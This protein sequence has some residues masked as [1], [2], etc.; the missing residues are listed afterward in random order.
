M[1]AKN[2]LLLEDEL[3]IAEALEHILREEGY[4]VDVAIAVAEAK[5]RLRA[6]LY[7]VMIADCRLPDGYGTVIR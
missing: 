4:A 7:D 1:P 5:E 6:A 2:I 3:L